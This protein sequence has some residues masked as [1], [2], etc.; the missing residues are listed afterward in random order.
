MS[1]QASLQPDGCCARF[2]FLYFEVGLIDL[3]LVCRCGRTLLKHPQTRTLMVFTNP[4]PE[5]RLANR[6]K[7]QLPQVLA[8]RPRTGAP[9]RRR[10]APA[11]DEELLPGVRVARVWR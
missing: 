11:H 2:L 7:N 10:G 8:H 9:A 6:G 4:N 1:L 5:P 3:L